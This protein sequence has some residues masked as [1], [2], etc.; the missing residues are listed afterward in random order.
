MKYTEFR[1]SIRDFLMPRPEDG[2]WKEIRVA[3]SFPCKSPCP[4]WVK[5]LETDIGLNRKERNRNIFCDSF[6]D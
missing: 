6:A 3:L 2:I 4:E 5:R 1:D